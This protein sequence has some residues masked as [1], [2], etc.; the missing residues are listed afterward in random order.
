MVT[1]ITKTLELIVQRSQVKGSVGLVPTMGNLHAGHI[2]LL[3]QALEENDVAYL[4]IFVNPKQ[5]GPNDDF[6]KYPRTLQNDIDLIQACASQYPSKKVFVYA[7]VSPEDIFPPNYNLNLAVTEFNAI[8]EGASRPGHFDGVATVVYR[9]FDLMKPT[10]AYFGLKDYQQ[11]LVISQMVKDLA[12]PLKI[13][14]MP[15]MREESGL[16]M[17]SRNQYLSAQQ[18][19]EGLAISQAMK[20]IK[21]LLDGKKS[22]LPLAQKE[23]N[24]LILD[25][26]WNYL[27]MLDAET[28]SDKLTSSKKITL[29]GVYQ[30]GTTRLLDNM[31][32]ELE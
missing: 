4:S 3:K 8:V 28:L 20:K 25:P 10:K 15:I 12:L 21:Q 29:L 19:V 22:N 1:V 5:F 11:Y 32:M 24:A 17:S 18:R 14:G 9:L 2:S 16:A 30:L 23:I 13:V 6:H 31:Q 26:K 7:P 27:L